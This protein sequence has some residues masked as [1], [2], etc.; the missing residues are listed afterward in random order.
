MQHVMVCCMAGNTGGKVPRTPR[1]V[2]LGA[3]LRQAREQHKVTLRHHAERLNLSPSVLSRWENGDRTPPREEVAR[4]L[5]VLGVEGDEYANIMALTENA[6]DPLWLAVT[7]PDERRQLDAFVTFEQ[8]ASAIT[9]VQSLL[10]PGLLQTQDYIHAVMASIRQQS[11]LHTRIAIRRGRQEILTQR[12][13]REPVK[14]VAYIGET[15][16]W[17]QIGTAQSMAEQ[18]SHL[19]T[20]SELPNIDIHILRRDIGWTPADT[21]AFTLIEADTPVPIVYVE[22]RESG[23]FLYD[24]HS[25]SDSRYR[26]AITMLEGVASSPDE[27]REIISRYQHEWESV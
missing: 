1:G 6:D 24:D 13:D 11:E 23:L 16:L 9:V 19:L 12:T 10:I 22:V 26:S 21:G 27:S 8:N 25:G 3:A 20:M 7:V 2:A 15:A 17:K 14:L 4:Y 18:M 5:T